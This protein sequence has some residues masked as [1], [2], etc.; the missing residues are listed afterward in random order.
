MPS[1]KHSCIKV[2]KDISANNNWQC[3]VRLLNLLDKL[4]LFVIFHR[5]KGSEKVPLAL[6]LL[7]LLHPLSLFILQVL[8]CLRVIIRHLP[9]QENLW[10]QHFIRNMAKVIS[11][12]IGCN[13]ICHMIFFLI[14][15]HLVHKFFDLQP[16]TL[17]N[18]LHYFVNIGR[19]CLDFY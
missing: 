1:I 12:L 19:N 4:F 5:I 2:A 17:R 18:L 11:N 9:K 15:V 6:K 10:V 3:R 7:L 16:S 13:P 14:F 8:H